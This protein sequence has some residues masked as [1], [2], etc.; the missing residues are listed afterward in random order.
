MPDWNEEITGRLRSAKLAPVTVIRC[1][2]YW[3]GALDHF[4][5]DQIGC[6]QLADCMSNCRGDMKPMTIVLWR[7]YLVVLRLSN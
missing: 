6:L 3:T 4:R 1:Y 5:Y 7:H 2:A